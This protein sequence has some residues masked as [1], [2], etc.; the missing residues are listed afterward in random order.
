MRYKYKKLVNVASPTGSGSKEYV[1]DT[2]N[3]REQ[4]QIEKLSNAS[5][6]GDKNF[7]V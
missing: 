1:T 5:E 7:S 4:A 2:A 6:K 3:T